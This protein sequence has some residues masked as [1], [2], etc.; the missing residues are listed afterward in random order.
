MSAQERYLEALIELEDLR[1]A[2]EQ[3]QRRAE[4]LS[5]GASREYQGEQR[6]RRRALDETS[7]SFKMALISGMHTAIIKHFIHDDGGDAMRRVI[8]TLN[9]IIRDHLEKVEIAGYRRFDHRPDDMAVRIHWPKMDFGFNIATYDK[10]TDKMEEQV[11][12]IQTHVVNEYTSPP[13]PPCMTEREEYDAIMRRKREA[14][15]AR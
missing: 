7:Q 13:I 12:R 6:G 15:E 9:R 11:R 14:R 8:Y 4:R 2:A 3:E 1:V 5:Y 10:L